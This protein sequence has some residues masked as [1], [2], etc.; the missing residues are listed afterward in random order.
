MTHMEN[1]REY[2]TMVAQRPQNVICTTEK[3]WILLLN[4]EK[5]ESI[6][7]QKW[8]QKLCQQ[9]IQPCAG[10]KQ[11]GS[12]EVFN[13]QDKKA[14]T[15]PSVKLSEFC[16]IKQ[17]KQECLEFPFLREQ[18][19]FKYKFGKLNITNNS[20]QNISADGI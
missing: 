9:A 10:G 8:K 7:T 12:E 19:D 20:W 14:C 4:K 1:F 11:S 3:W 2:V 17:Q 15:V 16:K 5:Q 13:K 18:L 6:L